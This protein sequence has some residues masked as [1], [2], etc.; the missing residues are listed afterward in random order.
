ML[1]CWSDGLVKLSYPSEYTGGSIYTKRAGVSTDPASPAQ[2]QQFISLT[3]N[4]LADTSYMG[5]RGA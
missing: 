2:L 5:W 1:S 3:V 4:I